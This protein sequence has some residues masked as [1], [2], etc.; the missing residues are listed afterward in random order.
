MT[1]AECVAR[2]LECRC[3]GTHV[4]QPLTQGRAKLVAH[5]P[6]EMCE[7]I[8]KGVRE[9]ISIEHEKVNEVINMIIGSTLEYG[10]EFIKILKENVKKSSVLEFKRSR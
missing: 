10:E 5:Y 8:A 2:N 1:N 7:A 9:Q 4:H 3:D 6:E